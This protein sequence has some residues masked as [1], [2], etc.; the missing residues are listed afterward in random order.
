LPFFEDFED[1]NAFEN[2]VK[3]ITKTYSVSFQFNNLNI[4]S[5]KLDFLEYQNLTKLEIEDRYEDNLFGQKISKYWIRQTINDKSENVKNGYFST[6]IGEIFNHKLRMNMIN[7]NSGYD[8]DLLLLFYQKLNEDKIQRNE[9][10]KILRELIIP[11]VDEIRPHKIGETEYLAVGLE[12]KNGLFPMTYFGDGVVKLTRILL[13]ILDA[14]GKRLMI[15]EIETGIH[16]SR[17]KD[18]WKTVI[19]LCKKYDVQLFATT[20]SLECQRYFVDAFTELGEEYQK[21]ARNISLVEDSEGQVK[22]V[23]FDF[24]QFEFAMEIGYNTRGGF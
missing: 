23:T 17:L 8:T 5:L 7:M 4:N 1:S 15:D 2:I 16:F 12:D 3:D 13:E 24:K 11:K 22:S 20:H 10:I 9:F 6:A 14:R 19:T 18:F 21:E